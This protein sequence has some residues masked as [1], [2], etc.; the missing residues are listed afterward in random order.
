MAPMSSQLA[1]PANICKVARRPLGK[2]SVCPRIFS[3]RRR[4]KRHVAT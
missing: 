4:E 1:P 2:V 3:W